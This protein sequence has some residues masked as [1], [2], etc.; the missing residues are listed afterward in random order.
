MSQNHSKL[1]ILG[2]LII[3]TFI[4]VIIIRSMLSDVENK[5]GKKPTLKEISPFERYLLENGLKK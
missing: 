4:F 3:T 1:L 2:G 5:T